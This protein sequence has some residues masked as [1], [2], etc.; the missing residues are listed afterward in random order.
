MALY[1]ADFGSEGGPDM[2]NALFSAT[3]TATGLELFEGVYYLV[4]S[5]TGPDYTWMLMV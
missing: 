5:T 2:D 3:T 4:V 1:P